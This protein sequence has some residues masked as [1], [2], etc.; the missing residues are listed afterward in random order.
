MPTLKN[1]FSKLA[2]NPKSL[3]EFIHNPDE[4]MKRAGLSD[5]DQAVLRSR[6]PNV[7]FARLA[8]LSMEKAFAIMSAG[9]TDYDEG[10]YPVAS[11][12]DP[13]KRTSPTPLLFYVPPP[14]IRPPSPLDWWSNWGYGYPFQHQYYGY[15]SQHQYY[16]SM[17]QY[18]WIP[19]FVPYFPFE[20]S[21]EQRQR[22]V[23]G[24]KK[25]VRISRRRR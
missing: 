14:N 17:P 20:S 5:E 15:P 8:G 11:G 25:R 16:P 13:V 1:F 12:A 23:R 7:I 9:E 18:I 6:F 4:A 21:G 3:G 10:S 24:S 22:S 19:Y 2:V